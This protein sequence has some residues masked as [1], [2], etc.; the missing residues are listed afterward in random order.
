MTADIIRVE[1]GDAGS[2]GVW[3][4]NSMVF[5]V[6]LELP[7]RIPYIQP[8]PCGTFPCKRTASPLVER[9]T[10]GKWKETFEITGYSGHSRVLVHPGNFITNTKL[11]V[12]VASSFGKLRGER[13]ILN[14]GATFNE[15][16]LCLRNVDE[17][18]LTIKEV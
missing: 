15:W 6:T 1:K 5:C 10:D 14:S 18:A 4:F 16:L 17:F 13:A 11:C 12:L 3:L 8:L 9:I 7:E 2:F